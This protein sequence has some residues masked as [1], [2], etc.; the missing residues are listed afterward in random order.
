MIQFSCSDY[1]FPLLTRKQS[2][3][4]I[5]LLQFDFVDLGLFARSEQ[6]SPR[7]LMADPLGFTRSL[8]EDLKEAGL[9]AA[10]LFL[11]IGEH[12]GESSANDPGVGVRQKNREVFLRTVEL[13]QQLAC[14]HLTGLP[15]V[16]HT[17]GDKGRDGAV[18][19]EEAIWR[20]ETA[21]QAGIVYSFEPHV[22]SL[23]A[24]VSETQALLQLIPGMTLTLDY[25]HFV[26]SGESS[27]DVHSLLPAASHLHARC[28]AKG[29]L[30]SV[31]KENEIDFTGIMQRLR[32][33]D[34]P[35]SIA[36]EYVWVDWEGCNR[37]DNLSETLQLREL[38]QSDV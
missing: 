6:L 25:G 29:K 11:Q 4:L 22:G 33:A 37:V 19:A 30:Q 24:T 1:T 9:A 21:L 3:Q 18:A 17:P 12:P 14:G 13:C 38:L 32:A 31:F 5:R 27:N 8:R 10:D 35:G 23:C 7:A 20:M 16:W 34:Y 28:G 2:L 26:T 15:G 36:L